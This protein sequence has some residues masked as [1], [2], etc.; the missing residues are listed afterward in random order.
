MT[1]PTAK[2]LLVFCL[3]MAASSLYTKSQ[4]HRLNSQNLFTGPLPSISASTVCNKID[5]GIYNYSGIVR[6][7]YLSVNKGN[8]VLA[9][10]FYG[11]TDEADPSKLGNIPTVIWLNGGPGSSS[12]FGNF[13]ELGPLLVSR[14]T[15]GGLNITA[16]KYSWASKYNV[17]FVDQPVG[18]GLSYADT[19]VKDVFVKSMDGNTRITQTWQ[20]ISMLL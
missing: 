3:L 4:F 11:K 15:N 12:Q 13:N 20:P 10:T 9:F 14:A 1:N 17:L 6:S 16:N 2:A 19:E 8:S 7:G 18:T 5:L